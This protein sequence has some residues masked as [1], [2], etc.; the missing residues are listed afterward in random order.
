MYQI[1]KKPEIKIKTKQPDK[2][3]YAVLPINVLKHNIT[4]SMYKVL[5]ALSSYCNK[6]GFSYVSLSKIGQDLNISAQAVQK[7]MAKLESLGI[8][9]TYKNYY[10][11]IKGST[12][13]IIY[14][15]KIKDTDAAAI[16]NEPIEPYTNAEINLLLKDKYKDNGQHN[17]LISKTNQSIEVD[18]TTLSDK[19]LIASIKSS[20]STPLQKAMVQRDYERGIPLDII[21]AK[22]IKD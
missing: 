10:T 8:V 19:E 22:Y 9:H 21:K 13:R 4:G 18:K 15:N 16:A 11:G 7:Q 20:V 17:K 3:H 1:P 6:A 14:D 5:V 2:R 12:R